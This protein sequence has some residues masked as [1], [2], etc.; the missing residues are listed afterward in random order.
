[1]VELDNGLLQ[2]IMTSNAMSDF[3]SQW[4]FLI[5]AVLAFAIITVTL[6]LVI[7][8]TKLAKARDNPD[9]RKEA[10]K[11]ILISGVCLSVLGSIGIIY[12][13]LVYVIL[14]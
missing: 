14:G 5:I 12:S 10:A 7:N 4:N 13:I 1:M 9:D 11:G 6:I 8:I 3:L 2:R